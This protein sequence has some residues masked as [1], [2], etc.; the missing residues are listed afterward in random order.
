MAEAATLEARK[1][2]TDDAV[3]RVRDLVVGFG[4]AIVLDHLNLDVARGEILGFVGGSGAGKSVLLRTLIGL[5]QKREGT[6]EILGLDIDKASQDELQAIERRWG[7]L[8]QQG[9]LFSSL[10]TLQ[11]V[12]FP[13]RENLHLSQRLMD[14]VAMAKLEMVGLTPED[15]AKSPSELSGGMVKRV[16]LARALS[17]DPEIVFLDEP[18]SGLDP[19]SAG[20]FDQLIRTLQQTLGL[21]VFMVTH[22]LDSLHNVCD[23]IAALAD[24]KVVAEGTIETMLASDHPWVKAYFR[25]QRARILTSPRQA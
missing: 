6:I 15:A 7:I 2:A 5:I 10:T 14:E 25:G 24:G 12:Q 20:E 9:A 22:D 19:I 17:L 3:I 8:F 23:R 18:T 1:T 4:D 13:M 21:T 11:N 16:A